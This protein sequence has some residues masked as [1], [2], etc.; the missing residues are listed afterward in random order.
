MVA[1]QFAVELRLYRGGAVVR[2]AVE[3]GGAGG[4]SL[5]GRDRGR[6]SKGD[7]SKGRM[8]DG[9]GADLDRSA[10]GARHAGRRLV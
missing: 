3:A 4:V 7:G 8:T 5:W 9:A 2:G 10:G 6:G 1:W